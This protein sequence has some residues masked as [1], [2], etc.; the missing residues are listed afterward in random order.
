[1]SLLL[2]RGTGSTYRDA[3]DE[4]FKKTGV[5]KERFEVTKWGYDRNGKSIPVEYSGPNGANVN[6]D[7]PDLN[8]VKASGELGKGPYQ[9]H[10]GYQTPG[11]GRKKVRGHIFV[12]NIPAT[13][14]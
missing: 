6:I 9:P 12:D 7:I 11:K 2:F 4:A 10:I 1:M 3:L 14:D 13:R 5:S 8:N